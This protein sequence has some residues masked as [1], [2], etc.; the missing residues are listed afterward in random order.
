MSVDT[1]AQVIKT[2]LAA[3]GEQELPAKD[4]IISVLKKS[5]ALTPVEVSLLIRCAEYDLFPRKKFANQ[6]EVNRYVYSTSRKLEL[7]H[8]IEKKLAVEAVGGIASGFASFDAEV[9]TAPSSKPMGIKL[10]SGIVSATAPTRTDAAVKPAVPDKPV[11]V[12]KEKKGLFSFLKR[13]RG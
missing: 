4:E 8:G 10:S 1:Q 13:E 7:D 6:T 9:S 3:S 12:Q 2:V 5:E 11:P